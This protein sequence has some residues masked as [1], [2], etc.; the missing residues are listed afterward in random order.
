MSHSLLEGASFGY[1][2][3]VNVSLYQ[4]LATHLSTVATRDLIFGN[5]GSGARYTL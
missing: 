1:T 2:W 3:L 4:L 5:T